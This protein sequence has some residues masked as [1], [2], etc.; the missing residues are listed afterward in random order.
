MS[1]EFYDVVLEV[2]SYA[3]KHLEEGRSYSDQL[4]KNSHKALLL[5]IEADQFLKDLEEH[6]FNIFDDAFRKKSFFKM[7]YAMYQGAK[8]GYY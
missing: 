7:P 8:K 2:A 4:P 6:N 3:K 5:A 1:E